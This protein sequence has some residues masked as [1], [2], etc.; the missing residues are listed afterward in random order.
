[1]NLLKFFGKSNLN[2]SS[3]LLF[4]KLYKLHKSLDQPQMQIK[5]KFSTLAK[6]FKWDNSDLKCRLMSFSDST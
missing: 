1:M 3:Q 6:V 2:N 4:P 5:K